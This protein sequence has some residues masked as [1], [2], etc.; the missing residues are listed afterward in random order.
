MDEQNTE[1]NIINPDLF[2]A[3]S[4]VLHVLHYLGNNSKDEGLCFILE[5][6]TMKLQ[7][8]KQ[9]LDNEI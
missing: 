1:K 5:R 3:V 7:F 6:C 2:D 9:E 4:E 8:V